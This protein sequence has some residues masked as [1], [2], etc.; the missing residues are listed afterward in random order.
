[1][2]AADRACILRYAFGITLSLAL[3]FGVEWMLSALAPI[4][5][6]SIL[7]KRDAQPSLKMTLAIL[8]AIAIIFGMGLIL[9]TFIYPYPFVFLL[10]FSALLFR[11]Y[12]A[13]ALGK[14]S[15]VVLLCTMALLLLPL[16]GTQSSALALVVAE[17]FLVSALVALVTVQIAHT[18]FP[19]PASAVVP[20][21]GPPQD[22][23]GA[24]H[25]AWLSTAV[26]LPLAL[27]CIIY[28]RTDAVF[29]LIMVALLSQKADFSVGAAGGKALIAANVGGG[30]VAVAFYK[31]LSIN[32][33]YVFVLSGIFALALLFARELFSDKP[34]A[35]LYGSAFSTVLI[36]IGTGSGAFGGEADS[37]FVT[38]VVQIVLAVCYV[39]A[40]LSLLEDV[41]IRERW[42]RYGRRIR[43][44][45][46]SV[47][48]MLPG[49]KHAV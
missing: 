33:S 19:V 16:L 46:Q 23:A 47:S 18:L 15:F 30:L 49:G 9:T 20:P 39:V 22:M 38:R 28:G 11:V 42:L 40:A 35:Q 32:P 25:S 8:L 21:P 2:T 5:T 24:L 17:G 13:A 31:L 44:R 29:P 45:L 37:K 48:R 1:M 27:F 7:G 36:L 6:A 41:N 4:L 10:L 34:T 12:L 43:R 26:V 14:S 3:A